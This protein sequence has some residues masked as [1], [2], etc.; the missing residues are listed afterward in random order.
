MIFDTHAHMDDSWF[1]D[2]RRELLESM[3]DNGVE[4]IV[5][6]AADTKSLKSTIQLVDEYDF[7]FGALGIHP[8]EVGDLNE[9]IYKWIEENLSHPKI[10]AVG[11]I[12][13]DYHREHD[14]NMQREAFERQMDIARRHDIPIVVHSRDAANDTYEIMKA[15]NA[16]EIGGVI[17]CFSY[18][19]EMARQFL[20]MNYYIGVGGVVTFKNGRKLKEVVEYTPLDRIVL[21][22]DAPYLAP[23]P[24]RGQRND[25]T[26]IKYV[27][28]E[29]ARIK[30]ISFDEVVE[31]TKQN[32][33][34]MYK[35]K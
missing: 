28:E 27:A 21:E 15:N 26:Y 6:I 22:T 1:D 34:K 12:G 2:D 4:T 20:D 23:T 7:V 31:T 11:E 24:F 17:H 9:E 35:M 13:M 10:V 19:K 25:S 30:N 16:Q 14:K 33:L 8:D 18:E 3:K 29:I 32:A 5:N